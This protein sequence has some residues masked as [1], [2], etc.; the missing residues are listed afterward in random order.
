MVNYAVTM[1]GGRGRNPGSAAIN[2]LSPY[3]FSI[4]SLPITPLAVF[5]LRAFRAALHQSS[6]AI[7]EGGLMLMAGEIASAQTLVRA[8]IAVGAVE[9][10][11]AKTVKLFWQSVESCA[12]TKALFTFGQ[13]EL[14]ATHRL[15]C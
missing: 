4:T 1:V 2:W 15:F 13:L 5:L 11:E 14:L 3:K 9:P 12:S 7:C 6:N 8:A 10:P